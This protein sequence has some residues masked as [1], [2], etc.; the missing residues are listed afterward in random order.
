MT[1]AAP[2]SSRPGYTAVARRQSAGIVN[3]ISEIGFKA[4]IVGGA[5]VGIQATAIKQRLGAK[6]NGITNYETWVPA[7]AWWDGLARQYRGEGVDFQGAEPP[8]A[9]RVPRS[10][11]DSVADN[12]IGN[13]LV[14]R[15]D[16]CDTRVQVELECGEPTVLL[17]QDRGANPVEHL[18]NALIGCLTTTMAYHAAARGIEIEAIDSTLEGDLDLRGF[19][20]ISPDVR[21]GYREIR[22]TMRVKSKASP[23]LLRELAQY[24]PVFDVCSR[25]LPVKVEVVTV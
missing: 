23:A 2:P 14:K 5:M 16:E 11:F 22:V 24:S 8:A 6:L 18:L 1:G 4:K 13:A 19:L 10:L 9:A 20:G 21:K 15:A 7:K 17:G 25:A 3:A 12:L